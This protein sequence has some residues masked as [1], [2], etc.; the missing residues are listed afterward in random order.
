MATGVA[1]ALL[2]ARRASLVDPAGVLREQ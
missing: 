2:P 1:G